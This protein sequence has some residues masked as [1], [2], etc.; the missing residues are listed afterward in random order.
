MNA[1][2]SDAVIFAGN[3]TTGA[4]H[5]LV[6]AL[7][8][9]PDD[10]VTVI[11]SPQEHHSNQLPWRNLPR[12]RVVV[13][14]EHPHTGQIDLQDLE[15]I[16]RE[17]STS[18]TTLIGCF[19]AASNVSGVMNDDLSV[20]ALVRSYGGLAFWDYATAAPYVHVNVNPRVSA[21]L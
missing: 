19:S 10:D 17:E 11:V 18:S 7:D 4:V 13:V 15:R 20:T 14:A 1:S 12:S 5:A 8:F 21:H 3:G 9:G 6:S 2:E 16:L